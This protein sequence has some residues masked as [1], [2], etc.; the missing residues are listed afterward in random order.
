M[1]ITAPSPV[2]SRRRTGSRP[3]S[4]GRP[5]KQAPYGPS[6]SNRRRARA[7][8]AVAGAR[9]AGL[10][11][12]AVV[13]PCTEQAQG[14]EIGARTGR[15]QVVAPRT[16]MTGKHFD[17]GAGGELVFNQ[18]G[19]DDAKAIAGERGSDDERVLVEAGAEKPARLLAVL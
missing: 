13:Q 14:G 19:R 2:S 1:R 8:G 18:A 7:E 9:I 12:P 4:T 10:V 16:G 17:Q 6:S 11:I 5:R 3:L 15:A